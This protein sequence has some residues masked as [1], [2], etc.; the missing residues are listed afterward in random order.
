[1][2]RIFRKHPNIAADLTQKSQLVKTAYMN[3]LIGLVK[4]LN[5]PPHSLTDTELSNARTE[6]MDLTRVGFKVLWLKTKLDAISRKRNWDEMKV[7]WK[8]NWD[9]WKVRL[10]YGHHVPYEKLN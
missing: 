1:M 6:L 4:T 8:R 9:E 5:K 7:R 3:L 2:T 10:G